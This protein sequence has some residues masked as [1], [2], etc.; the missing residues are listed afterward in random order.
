MTNR[1][2]TER[3]RSATDGGQMDGR[4]PR[5][6]AEYPLQYL[7]ILRSYGKMIDNMV[8]ASIK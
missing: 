1:V 8:F 6:F 3:F 2:P 7:T 4:F 5:F